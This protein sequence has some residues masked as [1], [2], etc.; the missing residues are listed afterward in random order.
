MGAGMSARQYVLWA[1]PLGSDATPRIL[2]RGTKRYVIQARDD[3]ADSAV[4]SGGAMPYPYREY[5]VLQYGDNITTAIREA[6]Q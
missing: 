3:Y 4:A 6:A 5:W 1:R 2:A